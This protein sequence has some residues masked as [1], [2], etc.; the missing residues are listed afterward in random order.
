MAGLFG[1]SKKY[2]P[3]ATVREEPSLAAR[4]ANQVGANLLGVDFI[5]MGRQRALGEAQRRFMNELGDSLAPGYEDGPPLQVGLGGEPSQLEYTP[6]VRTRDPIS[7]NSPELAGIALKAARLGVPINQVLDVLKAQQPDIAVGPDGSTYNKKSSNVPARFAT[8][9]TINGWNVD[10]GDP[11]NRGAY[12]PQLPS[13]MIP[14]GKGGVANVTGLSPAMQEQEEAQA[15]GRTRGTMFTVPRR[16]GGTGLMTGGQYLGGP[17]AR[18]LQAEGEFGVSQSPDDAAYA[19]ETAKAAATQYT[20]IQTA[21]QRASGAI[22]NYARIGQLLDGLNTGRFTPAGKE[23]A[24]AAAS[25]GIQVNPAWGNVE[26][27]DALSKKL[28]LDAMGGSLG[29]GFSNADRAF[30]EGMN[31]AIVNTPQ[32]RKQIIAFGVARA[33]RD[34]QV[35]QMARQWQQR[36]GRLDKP[37]RNGK[38]F[39]DYLDAFAEANPLMPQAR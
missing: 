32:G 38:T 28:A 3:L 19:A 35:A 11:A 31:P 12:F 9:T 22:S 30:V 17:G 37:D 7:I 34:Q 16:G 33:K 14:N 29:A 36:A 6:P 1:K 15:L 13:G 8:P 4:L 20:A 23:I 26:A 10:S 24:K 27:A 25:F 39:F 18:G 2:D 21:G 5:G